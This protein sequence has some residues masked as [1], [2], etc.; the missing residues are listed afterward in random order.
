MTRLIS[1]LLYLSR[2]DSG[3][4]ILRIEEVNIS[5]LVRFVCEK[6]RIHANKKHQSLLCNVQEDIIIDA[7]RDRL[8]QVLINLINNAITYVQDGGRIEVCLK[9]ENGNIEL[10]VED[11]GPGIPK[12]DLPRIFERFYRVDKARSRSLGGSGLGLSIADEIV[13]A[14]GG[15]VLVESEEGVGTKFTVVLP[16]KEKGQVTL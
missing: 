6:M 10:T 13:K 14:H 2:L 7:D 15:R 11:N 1:D 4:N 9:K 5:E 16:L 3:E 8:E 12:E